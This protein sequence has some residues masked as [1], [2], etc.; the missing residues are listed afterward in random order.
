MSTGNEVFGGNFG[1]QRLFSV[2]HQ[3]ISWQSFKTL[4]VLIKINFITDS[5]TVLALF[6]TLVLPHFDYCDTVYCFTSIAN[7]SHLGHLQNNSCRAILLTDLFGSLDDI[8]LALNLSKLDVRC[9][10]HMTFT[11][12]KNIY[13]ERQA[14]LGHFDV[15]VVLVTGRTI[16]G[17]NFKT[18]AVPNAR[19]IFGKYGALVFGIPWTRNYMKDLV[20]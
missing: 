16:R 11:C 10:M 19:T 1:W 3:F 15:L 2:W 20:I 5:H 6:K 13:S 9:N 18:M 12:H 8:H 7:S 17:D 14:S 4:T